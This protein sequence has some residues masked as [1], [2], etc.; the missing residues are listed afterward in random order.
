MCNHAIKKQGLQAPARDAEFEK[1][2][3]NPLSYLGKPVRKG[4]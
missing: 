3:A 4:T 2:K 1:C